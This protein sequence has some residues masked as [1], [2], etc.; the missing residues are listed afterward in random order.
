MNALQEL[1]K[2]QPDH[3]R[4]KVEINEVRLRLDQERVNDLH[5]EAQ[6]AISLG[7]YLQAINSLQAI[8][9]IQPNNFSVKFELE[10]AQKQHRIITLYAE[11]Q[12][13]MSQGNWKT[14]VEKFELL[15]RIDPSLEDAREALT[16]AQHNLKLQNAELL[17]NQGHSHYRANR[18]RQALDNFYK[19][20]GLVDGYKDSEDMIRTIESILSGQKPPVPIQ[21]VPEKSYSAP[22]PE[23]RPGITGEGMGRKYE[24]IHFDAD[25]LAEE[26]NQYFLDNGY[27]AQVIHQDLNIM[28]QGK[29]LGLRRLV[30]MG[31]ATSIIIESTDF[32]GEISIGGGKWA[33]QGAAIAVGLYLWPLLV[34]GGVGMLQQKELIDTL[35]RL[36]E[37]HISERGGKRML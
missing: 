32:G 14:A 35:W 3:S 23:A 9:R 21:S 1:L 28:V 6:S 26:L 15:I 36:I 16:Y 22:T 4:A 13:A 5:K 37:K 24:I 2:I 20:K 27:E 19:V 11:A 18:F 8:L 33:E 17:Y 10:Q 29:K 12:T 30:G 25:A 31:L 34:T 7:N